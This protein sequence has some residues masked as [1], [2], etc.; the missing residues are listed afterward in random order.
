MDLDGL[1]ALTADLAGRDPGPRLGGEDRRARGQYGTPPGLAIWV[2]REVLAPL[3]AG[4]RV[5]DP[6]A[7]DGRFLAAA[8]DALV[9]AGGDTAAVEARLVGFER[10]P[11]LAAIARARLPRATIVT[12]EALCEA[13]AIEVD[14]VI[15]NPPYVR[16][17][18]L[19][20]ADPALWTAIR[21]RFAATSHG[22]WDLYAAFVE[23]ALTWVRPGGRIGLVTPSR[24]WS[25]AFAA[26]LRERLCADGAVRAVVDFGAAQ[27]FAG[28]TTYAAVTI[29]ARDAADRPRDIE[30]ARFD[31]GWQ[32]G[33][34][35]AT[36]L[37]AA[38]WRFAVGAAARAVEACALRGPALGAI[39]RIVKGA[40]TNADGVFVVEEPVIAGEV[41]TG[42]ARGALVTL[43][44]AA[45]R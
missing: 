44:L 35:R 23:R 38:P 27:V 37:G 19:R 31:R 39:A 4:A 17:I 11:E 5:L 22:E 20:E 26:R 18:R 8:R 2:A 36:S 7:G 43:E 6:S 1:R 21:G 29:L 45:T 25:A 10:D 30:V 14:A 9:E 32:A 16:S 24:W 3:G 42:R 41:V 34:V 28:A 13:P 12:C 15:G 33:A 40:G